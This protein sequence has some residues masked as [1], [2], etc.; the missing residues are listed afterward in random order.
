MEHDIGA[1]TSTGGNGASEV[2]ERARRELE[3][4]R[5]M[6]EGWVGRLEDMIR[7][8]PGTTLLVALAAGFIVGRLA[9]GR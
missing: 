6:I 9:R 4:G 5:E 8:R 2:E 1:T 7:R 3:R